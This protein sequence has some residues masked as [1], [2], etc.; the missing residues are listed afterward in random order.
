MNL[1]KLDFST[2][3][4]LASTYFLNKSIMFGFLALF[5]IVYAIISAIIMYHWSSYGM[6]SKGIIIGR[7]LFLIV[8]VSLFLI[9]IL[10]LNYL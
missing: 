5:F 3:S 9:A 4:K 2:L 8:S 10:A 6:D 7:S 1:T